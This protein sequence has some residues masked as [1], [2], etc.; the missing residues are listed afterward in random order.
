MSEIK[1]TAKRHRRGEGITYRLR[2]EGDGFILK[3]AYGARTNGLIELSLYAPDNYNIGEVFIYV[4]YNGVE[5]H[6]AIL[7]AFTWLVDNK[8][9]VK[10]ADEALRLLVVA[11]GRLSGVEVA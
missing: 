1:I 9:T 3:A 5:Q 7:E 8:T 4:P 6:E 11:G 10:S 2:A